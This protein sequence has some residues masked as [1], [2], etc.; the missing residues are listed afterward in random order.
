MLSEHTVSAND[1]LLL[2]LDQAMD[3]Q[4]RSG[5]C[6]PLLVDENVH[7]RLLRLMYAKPYQCYDV[8]AYMRD[9]PLLFGI[10][11][12]YKHT[13]TVVY[14]TFFPVLGLLESPTGR[15]P[16]GEV[17]LTRKVVYMEKVFATLILCAE[18]VLPRVVAKIDVLRMQSRQAGV[19][20]VMSVTQPQPFTLPH[21]HNMFSEGFIGT[22]TTHSAPVVGSV[23]TC[24]GFHTAVMLHSCLTQPLYVG[25]LH[26]NPF[27]TVSRLQ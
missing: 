18:A 11:H 8:Q 4:V 24:C 2:V 25:V 6:M 23:C 12:A 3:I 27:Q 22:H 20:R 15:P 16:L 17:C 7:Y 26:I 13:V 9:M 14:R 19:T 21:L 1:A 5:L 10:W